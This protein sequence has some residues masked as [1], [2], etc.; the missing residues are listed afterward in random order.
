MSSCSHSDVQPRRLFWM[1]LMLAVLAWR[2][3]SAQV[4]GAEEP[5]VIVGSSEPFMTG[6]AGRTMI[7]TTP[8]RIWHAT[9]G[10]GQE[11][12]ETAFGGR[13]AFDLTDAVGFIDGQFRL[14]NESRG[15]ANIGG[16]VRWVT[17]GLITSDPRIFGLTGWYDG[18]ETVIGN[19][20]NQLG[21]SVES[22]GE[23]VDVRLNANIPLESTK[24]GDDIRFSGVPGYTGNFLTQQTFV[25]ADTPLRVVDFEVAPRIYNLNAWFYGG[26]YQMDGDDVSD[27]GAKGGAR[28]YVTND[29]AVDVGVTDDDVFGT[30]TRFQIIWT[31]GRTGSGPT[32]WIH[33]LAD[34]MRE[35]VYR[36]MY[37]ATARAEIIDNIALTDADGQ[38]IRVVHVDSNAGPGAG[39]GTFEDPLRSLND[40]NATSEAGDII[41]VHAESVHDGQF[42]TLQNEQRFLGEGDDLEHLVFT[43]ELGEIA[44][45]ETSLGAR[46]L[47][48]PL[49][50]N[51]PGAAAILMAVS[52][53]SIDTFSA[54]EI[55]NFDVNGGMR[56]ILSDDDG[57]GTFTGIGDI[58]IN[59]LAIT[60]TTNNAIELTP[61]VGK[62]ANNSNQ[63]RFRPTI[64]EV[65]FDGIGGDDIHIN[66]ETSAP[67]STAILE[68]ITITNVD[69]T[70]GAGVGVNLINTKRAVSIRD[71]TWDGAAV[72]SLVNQGAIRLEDAVGNVTV[73]NATISG[74]ELGTAFG[75]ALIDSAGTHTF[76]DTTITDTGGDSVLVS[77]GAANMNFTGRIV[78]S[79]NAAVLNVNSEHTGS[80]TFRE[81]TTGQGVI[82]ATAGAGL[83]F[84][85]ADGN[86]TFVHAVELTG[87]SAGIN[88]VN[89]SDGVIT[90]SN[91]K[92]TNATGTAVNFDGGDANM[93]F[94]GRIEQTANNQAVLTVS[95]E[96]TGT[97]T[98]NELTS[99]TGVIE[100]NIGP[101]LVFDNA[102][103][104]YIFNHEV[105]L[106]GGEARIAVQNDS[107]GT[108]TFA[109]ADI[110]FNGTG[111]AVL[112]DGSDVQAF[113]LTGEI[114]SNGAASRPVQV[115]NNTGGSITFNATIDANNSL[116]ILI[117]G[118]EDTTVLFTN[119][120]T[121]ETG[122]NR[123]IA[124]TNNED[125]SITF[126]GA[127]EVE[128][129]LGLLVENNEDTAVRFAGATEFD[130]DDFDAV[131]LNNNEDGSIRFDNLT[132]TTDQGNGF[133][134][135]ASDN[136][137]VQGAN[138]SITTNTGV[139]LNLNDVLVGSAGMTFRSV[140]VVNGAT[141]GIIMN[142]VRG[143]QVI[144]T[145][146]GATDG[147]GGTI[148][149]ESDAISITNAANVSINNMVL[150]SNTG[151]GVDYNV[152]TSPASRL[153]LNNNNISNTAP[154]ALESVRLNINGTATLANITL[155]ANNI[156]NT[157]DAS[158]VL[159]TIDGVTGKT[160]NLL[161]ENNENISNDSANANTAAARFQ[162]NGTGTLNATVHSNHFVS[163]GGPNS[164]AF[165]METNSNTSRA[166][167]DL[168]QNT[169][170]APGVN[171]YRL[172]KNFGDFSVLD[173]A[174]VEGD[175]NGVID[176]QPNKTDFDDDAGPIPTPPTGP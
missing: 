82:Q 108:F 104:A 124:I 172:E 149:A 134:A 43:R 6:A 68:T 84:D 120:V 173:L 55:S 34:R 169:A 141:S 109:D 102:D 176:F 90:V 89:D 26:G 114:V 13:M 131:T 12:S 95:N 107:E 147:S 154:A 2:P 133:T 38:N 115:T 130:T 160:V 103:G 78:Q 122:A 29:L 161:V 162:V 14:S 138:G 46:S 45:P 105:L 139:A 20:F 111:A 42:V 171:D 79:N 73:N 166:R 50:E 145:G 17:P 116:G 101:G 41:L 64:D 153:V 23:Y 60:N 21:V 155:R 119:E 49:I 81:Q 70:N 65:T 167:L 36:N 27:L 61:L 170:V 8:L 113:T 85:N 121:L 158:A 9:R 54:I 91:G 51:A 74:G 146:T 87:V 94:T 165:E 4:V 63:V 66:A 159:L 7:G 93:T 135:T 132:I 174:G 140:N 129:S 56:A 110:T 152:T 156:A 148:A 47:D 76:T 58:N 75:I 142:D 40:V 106:G 37:V 22:L 117:D 71:F 18:Q 28:G 69:S 137:T 67:A 11:A 32:S 88:V 136:V 80:L 163:T 157:T 48:R 59:H 1:A 98:F 128:D 97:L 123:S 100:A 10:F 127:V 99:G 143:G 125:S 151:R 16:G 19:Y 53:T 112:I 39:T 52:N 77:D 25:D 144:I 33:T 35:P 92:I 15:G 24:A 86:Y 62:L 72:T 126:N 168:S 175:N 3:V 30:T 118:N 96:H 31:P 5:P 44:L 164:I 57:A 150:S 83:Q